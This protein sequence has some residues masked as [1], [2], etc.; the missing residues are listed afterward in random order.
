[1]GRGVDKA[2]QALGQIKGVKKMTPLIRHYNLY[3]KGLAIFCVSSA[4]VTN[5]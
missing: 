1:M 4:A 3:A 2:G 5:P